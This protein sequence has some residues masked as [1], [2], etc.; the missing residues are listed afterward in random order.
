MPMPVAFLA[1]PRSEASGCAL[2]MQCCE[3]CRPAALSDWECRGADG[4]LLRGHLPH[5]ITIFVSEY[6]NG[7][8]SR[9]VAGVVASWREPRLR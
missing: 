1:L 9:G 6:G 3:L 7:Q 8:V 2:S 5:G 4:L